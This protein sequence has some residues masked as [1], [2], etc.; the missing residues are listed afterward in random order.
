[1]TSTSV[2]V[3]LN[4]DFYEYCNVVDQTVHRSKSGIKIVIETNLVK[5]E[6][7][8]ENEEILNLKEQNRKLK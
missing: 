2:I 4:P 3:R 1:M 8:L 5:T 6:Y 7:K